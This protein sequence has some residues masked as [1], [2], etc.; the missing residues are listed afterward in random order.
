[1]C[2]S[3]AILFNTNDLTYQLLFRIKFNKKDTHG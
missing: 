3:N 1:M 2:H